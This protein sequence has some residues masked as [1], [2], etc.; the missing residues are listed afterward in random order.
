MSTHHMGVLGSLKPF[1]KDGTKDLE[2]RVANEEM[3]LVE[4]GDTIIFNGQHERQV[5]A[6]RTYTTFTAMLEGEDANRIAPNEPREHILSILKKIYRE[7]ENLG[8]LVFELSS[9]TT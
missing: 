5:I 1:I 3:Q 8:V 9:P 2:I 7:R 6:I 4:V